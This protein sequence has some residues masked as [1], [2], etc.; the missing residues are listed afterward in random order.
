M[1]NVSRRASKIKNRS[2]HWTLYK[3]ASKSSFRGVLIIGT[4]LSAMRRESI[5][6]EYR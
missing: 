1:S 4:Y 3:E 5:D 6:S 2:F